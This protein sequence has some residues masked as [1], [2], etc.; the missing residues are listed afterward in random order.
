[1][2]DGNQAPGKGRGGRAKRAPEGR[3]RLPGG[4]CRQ[5]GV[6]ILGLSRTAAAQQKA[7]SIGRP[8]SWLPVL[9]RI[10]L[11]FWLLKTN[12]VTE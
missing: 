11:L 4:K 9:K 2:G 5:M 10:L 3:H 1:M 6:G 8:V 7:G 12:P